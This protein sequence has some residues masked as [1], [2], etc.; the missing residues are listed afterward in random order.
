MVPQSVTFA[1]TS[2][3]TAISFGG[4][5]G[6]VDAP[7]SLGLDNTSFDLASAPG[8]NVGEGLLGFAAISVLLIAVRFRSLVV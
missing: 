2:T 3:S 8:P 7:Y 6:A 1:A 5:G 4:A